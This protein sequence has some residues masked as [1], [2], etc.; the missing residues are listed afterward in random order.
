[1]K[2]FL[3]PKINF[4]HFLFLSYFIVNIIRDNLIHLNN[5][6]EDISTIFNHS[7]ICTLSD[8]LSIIPVL[9][10]KQR[11]KSLKIYEDKKI[12]QKLQT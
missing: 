10:I 4:N 8:F 11:S 5:P 3:F 6:T 9:T 7:Y 12:I 2:Y 1:M